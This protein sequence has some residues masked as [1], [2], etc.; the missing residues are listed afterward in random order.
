[1]KRSAATC[2][3]LSTALIGISVVAMLAAPQSVA[4]TITNFMIMA[5][6]VVGLGV[7]VG[8]SGVLSFGHPAFMALAAYATAILSIPVARKAALFPNLPDWLAGVELPWP[9]AGAVAVCLVAALGSV[10]GLALSRLG[11]ASATIASLG[12]MIMVHNI[13]VADTTFSRGAQAVFG[14]PKGVS[15]V[16]AG[17]SA[18]VAVCLT[19]WFKFSR[20]GLL[21]RAARDNV[22][23]AAA[24]G[25][26]ARRVHTLAFILS[27]AI[28][29]TGG[30]LFAH[31]IGV[32]SPK[33]F[34]LAMAFTTLA[35][36]IVGG[37]SSVTGA[38]IGAGLITLV[39]EILRRIEPGLSLGSIETPA[40]FGLT[41]IGVS[42][43]LLLTLYRRPQGLLGDRELIDR[44]AD[45]PT[46]TTPGF[47]RHTR[48]QDTADI[49]L[50]AR[51]L[52]KSY[53][54]VTALDDVSISLAKGEIVGLIGPNGSGK[55]TF[56]SCISGV[57]AFDSG[58]VTIGSVSMRNASP[59]DYA[60]NGVARTFQTVRLFSG[61]SVLENITAAALSGAARETP[62]NLAALL[63]DFGLAKHAQ[64]PAADLPYGDQ[65]R[66]EIARA[67]AL[68]P[69][70]L[71]LDE[72]AAG[73]NDIET[74]E[75]CGMLAEIR[76]RDGVGILLVDHDVPMILQICDR[77]AVL[78]EGRL[79]A[80]GAPQVVRNDPEVIRAYFG[81]TAP[82]NSDTPREP[83]P[84][85]EG[86]HP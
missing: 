47:R 79:I 86:S 65:R 67:L 64:S 68:A 50:H 81:R 6:V 76:A 32:F 69:D 10:V 36:L 52:V 23:A 2:A 60:R 66:V 40:I 59:S 7:Y 78:N 34:Y 17:V 21:A 55:S 61:L 29:A 42:L 70:F 9:L 71:L 26:N 85:A 19:L 77:V 56:L 46:P 18:A 72:P 3:I 28:T 25:I 73:M 41:T 62:R 20:T 75:L 31:N 12:L 14:V 51:K 39:T 16:V 54:G 24:S 82:A 57:Q 38:L 33:E 13:L 53:G 5:T 83:Q 45:M 4:N 8:S 27:V 1:M 74:R 35:M 48:R 63:D 37:T 11:G 58:D 22:T 49:T 44:G 15:P 80:E 30:V 84:Q 43:A